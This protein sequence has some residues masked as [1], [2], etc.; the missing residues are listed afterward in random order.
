MTDYDKILSLLERRYRLILEKYPNPNTATE[1]QEQELWGS[2]SRFEYIIGNM[3]VE[4]TTALR[5]FKEGLL[6]P[7][8]EYNSKE[9]SFKMWRMKFVERL[10]H[11]PVQNVTYKELLY[12]FSRDIIKGT[13][14]TYKGLYFEQVG[15]G[16]EWAVY[17]SAGKCLDVCIF[18]N[19]LQQQEINKASEGVKKEKDYCFDYHFNKLYE[20]I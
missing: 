18:S 10:R 1:I 2:L 3:E 7:D 12:C 19:L 17:N 5:L 4:P 9:Y 6:E 15:E 8:G 16:N 14:I 11:K 20:N 13:L